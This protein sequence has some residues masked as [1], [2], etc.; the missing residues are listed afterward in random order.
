ME[1]GKRND[2]R[3]KIYPQNHYPHLLQGPCLTIIWRSQVRALLEAEIFP[4]VS[5]NPFHAAFHNYP[6]IILVRLKYY[7]KRRKIAS[8]SSIIYQAFIHNV[9]KQQRLCSDCAGAQAD[10][11]LFCLHM[12][13]SPYLHMFAFTLCFCLHLH[14]SPYF[15]C[16]SELISFHFF[17]R[18]CRVY[19]LRYV[20]ES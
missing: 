9:C 7:L 18:L 20:Y 5:E 2:R 19:N 13:Y 8:H 1:K 14:Y 11:S 12:H 15:S 17:F 3:E 4:T 6:T 16:M 10:L